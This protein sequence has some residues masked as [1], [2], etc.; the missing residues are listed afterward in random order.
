MVHEYIRSIFGKD[1]AFRAGTISTIAEKTA[2]GYVKGYLEKKNL[3]MRKAEMER[4]SKKIVG[5][6]CHTVYDKVFA[7]SKVPGGCGPCTIA[8]LLK[9]TLL[10]C[11]RKY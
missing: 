8:M 6:V 2:F 11:E 10:A 3:K 5:D 9:N 4:R 1:R 7:Y